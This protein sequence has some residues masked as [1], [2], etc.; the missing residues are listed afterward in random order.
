MW[1]GTDVV[2]VVFDCAQSAI[3]SLVMQHLTISVYML[4][5]PR[6]HLGTNSDEL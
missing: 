1:L 4:Q 5:V 3:R 6:Q 2:L